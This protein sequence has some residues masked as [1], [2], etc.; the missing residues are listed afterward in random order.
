MQRANTQTLLFSNDD[1]SSAREGPLNAMR[2]EIDSLEGNRLLNTS[3]DDLC[4]YCV[5]KYRIDVPVLEEKAVTAAHRETKVLAGIGRLSYSGQRRR[6]TVTGT[7]VEVDVPFT[8]DSEMLLVRPSTHTLNPPRAQ[9][10]NKGLLRIHIEGAN[11]NPESVKSKVYATIADIQEHLERLRNDVGGF[12]V[13]LH[14]IAKAHVTK[15]RDKLLNDQKLVAHLEF[16]LRERTDAPTTFAAP[17]VRRRVAPAI[18]KASVAPFSPE[19]TLPDA[20]FAHI[21]SVIRNMVTVMERSPAAFST[22]NE[23]TLRTH[24]LVQ[25]NG[26][27][28]GNATGETFNYQGKTD[29]LI[30]VEGKNIFIAECKIWNGAKTLSSAI[31]QLLGYA[32]WRDTKV[33]VVVFNRNKD[34]SRVIE[35]IPATV[36]QH[37]NYKR[38]AECVAG[39]E[40]TCILGHRDD[41]NRELTM[42][43]VAFDVPREAAESQ[44]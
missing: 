40:F 44:G 26:H 18:R 12:N 32:S 36:K 2:A 5:E 41:P 19:P 6:R 33:A 10:V 7:A 43:V 24:I 38:E 39:A 35:A 1:W 42:A 31:D 25:L 20:E 29:I 8:G 27:Y 3:V 17:E 23:E 16:P 14:N 37:P 15:R 21:I 11:L 22:M 9:I 28:E 13:E 4:E 34:F 30:R